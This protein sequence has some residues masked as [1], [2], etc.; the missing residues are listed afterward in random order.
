MSLLEIIAFASSLA[1]V[2]LAAYQNS[3]C[4]LFSLITVSIYFFLYID[5]KLYG[6]SGL[7]I[8]YVITTIYGWLSWNNFFRNNEKENKTELPVTFLGTKFNLLLILL[9]LSA[10]IIIGKIMANSTDNVYPY[11]D[12]LT[13]SASVAATIM[14]TR[15]WIENW[16]WWIIIDASAIYLH[17]LREMYLTSGLFFMFTVMAFFGYYRWK[18]DS[19]HA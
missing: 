4:W 6:E 8:F 1:Y 5:A 18:K 3:W 11:W 12:G 10:G 15:K 2:I 17:V 16:I 13:L 14:T 7:Q 19:N 9:M